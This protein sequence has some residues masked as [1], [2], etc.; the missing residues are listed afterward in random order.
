[1]TGSVARNQT[2]TGEKIMLALAIA[3]S[4]AV[5]LC[6][7]R[8]Q[9]PWHDRFFSSN[10]L[11]YGLPQLCSLIAVLPFSPRLTSL[12]G[13]SLL[14]ALY[15]IL[16]NLWVL[17][18]PHPDGGTWGIY[19]IALIAATIGTIQSVRWLRSRPTFAPLRVGAVSASSA[20][21][22]I[23]IVHSLFFSIVWL[24]TRG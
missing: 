1:V 2:P 20:F 11:G 19:Y 24:G 3:V 9:M 6:V 14:N 22:G 16:F 8:S 13:V 7:T 4:I 21:A 15:L 5:T 12:I 18:S 23:L 17:S 10:A